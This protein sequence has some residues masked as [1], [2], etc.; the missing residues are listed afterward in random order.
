MA[1]DGFKV[2]EK[3]MN[4]FAL[5]VI[6]LDGTTHLFMSSCP[7]V[8]RS[9]CQPHVFCKTAISENDII[10]NDDKMVASDTPR[11]FLPPHPTITLTIHSHFHFLIW[12][13]SKASLEERFSGT[14][15]FSDKGRTST[16]GV[17]QMRHSFHH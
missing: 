11:D 1:G 17:H 9:V 5:A 2:C 16:A 10:N 8:R 7:S 15:F 13:N 12:V 6:F 14:I 4:F 3:E